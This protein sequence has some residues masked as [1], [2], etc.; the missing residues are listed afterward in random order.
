MNFPENLQYTKEH[1]WIRIEGNNAYIGITDFAQNE[2]GEIVYVDITT[3]GETLKKG[4][5]FGNVEA[6]KAV[7]DLYMP[8]S[9]KIVT[10]NPALE[11]HPELV[12]EDSYGE[13]WIIQIEIT[14]EADKETLL[15]A[16]DYRKLI[17]K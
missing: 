14:E 4:Q 16:E 13:G 15:T 7:S 5:V 6:V 12:N 9:G 1:E 11:E 3:E 17:N 10:V 8:V 2:L